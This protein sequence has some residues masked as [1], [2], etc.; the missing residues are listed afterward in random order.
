M[1]EDLE[2]ITIPLK[3][4]LFEVDWTGYDETFFDCFSFSYVDLLEEEV[5][6]ATSTSLMFEEWRSD[7]KEE[8]GS[9]N[10]ILRNASAGDLGPD[11]YEVEHEEKTCA[12]REWIGRVLGKIINYKRQHRR[13]LNE[14]AASLEFALPRDI[15]M[16]SVLSFFPQLPRHRF[17]GEDEEEEENDYYDQPNDIIAKGKDEHGC[18]RRKMEK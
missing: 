18:K 9:I 1:C 13:I 3:Q 4:D 7:M 15:I 12:I 2:R 10:Q 17:D 6:N 11:G 5:L 16:K 8:I 14:A